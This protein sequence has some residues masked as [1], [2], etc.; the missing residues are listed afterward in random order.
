[1]NFAGQIGDMASKLGMVKW[2]RRSIDLA[3]I[4]Y[5]YGDLAIYAV[6]VASTMCTVWGINYRLAMTVFTAI[7]SPFCFGSFTGTR[8]VRDGYYIYVIKL[9]V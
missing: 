8:L 6:T 4:V 5:L 7:V 2:Q 9:I 1:M 3:L